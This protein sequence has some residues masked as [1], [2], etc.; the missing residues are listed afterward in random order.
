MVKKSPLRQRPERVAPAIERGQAIELH[1]GDVHVR[2]ELVRVVELEDV[3]LAELAFAQ[4]LIVQLVDQVERAIA[5]A[6]GRKI[7][8]QRLPKVA[9]AIAREV[10]PTP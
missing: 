3:H 7:R 8:R 1:V 10:S 4:S 2:V 6:W 5:E 9:T